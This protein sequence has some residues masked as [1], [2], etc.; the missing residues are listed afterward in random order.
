MTVGSTG[1]VSNSILLHEGL[2]F[3]T[4]ECGAV[5]GDNHLKQAMH[6]EHRGQLGNGVQERCGGY[7]NHFQP[8]R[9]GIYLHQKHISQKEA[10]IVDVQP[11]PM[12]LGPVSQVKKLT[13]GT[14]LY[15]YFY[16]YR[17]PATTHN[18]G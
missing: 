11:H 4:S 10:G 17:F 1:D 18:F 2:E 3:T 7:G 12:V 8:L 15:V 5:V 13:L 6:C 14:A 9:V 16:V